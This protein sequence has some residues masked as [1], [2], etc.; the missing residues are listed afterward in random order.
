MGKELVIEKLRGSENYHTW[1]FAMK[2]VLEFEE[3]DGTIAEVNTETDVTK[4]KKA[5]AR[6]VVSV[7]ESLYVHIQGHTTA[8]GVWTTLKQL[9]DDKSLTRKITL[10][11]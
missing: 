1:Q 9:F 6:I 7:D 11:R 8:I 2:S 3:L 4:V 5:R 10:L